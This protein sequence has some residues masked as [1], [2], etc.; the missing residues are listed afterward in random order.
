M[1]MTSCL[2]ASA[3]LAAPPSAPVVVPASHAVATD[4][5][6]GDDVPDAQREQS[7]PD[8]K[9][10]LRDAATGIAMAAVGT[11]C[12]GMSVLGLGLVFPYVSVVVA[13]LFVPLAAAVGVGSGAAAWLAGK[14]LLNHR[15]PLVPLI[16]S[17]GATTALA[18]LGMVL[19]Y[20]V[21]VGFS[22]YFNLNS[23]LFS[24]QQKKGEANTYAVLGLTSLVGGGMLFLLGALGAAVVPPV[25]ATT[26]AS[27]L[28]RQREPDEKDGIDFWTVSPP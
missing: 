15:S 5:H 11:Q 26:L 13:A 21:A 18:A 16:L 24:A 27:V 19:G 4:A 6:D 28:G 25:L 8:Q 9:V 12:A 22:L 2:L 10:E 17:S 3:L 23:L 20:V 14:H 1:T 7:T